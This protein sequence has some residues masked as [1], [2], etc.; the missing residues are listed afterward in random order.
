MVIIHLLV[1]AR[2]HDGV[3][4]VEWEEEFLFFLIDTRIN[5]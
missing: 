5:G 4:T 1:L 2:G 3:E